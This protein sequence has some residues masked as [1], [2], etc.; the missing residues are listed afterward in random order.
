MRRCPHTMLARIEAY[1]SRRRALGYQL[2]S[3]GNYLLNFARYADEAGHRGPPRTSLMLRWA[4]LTRRAHRPSWAR[5]LQIVR[6]FAKDC[7][8]WEPRTQVPPRHFFGPVA[9]RPTPYLYSQKQM[10][11]LLARARRL[12]GPRQPQTYATLLGLLACTGLR[13]S[14]ALGLRVAD[15]DLTGGVLRINQSKY[16]KVRWVPLH[17]RTVARLR[18]YLRQRQR[19]FPQAQ[20]LFLAQNA[21][22]LTRT[23]VEKTFRGLRC[24]LADSGT[25]RLHDLRH[26]FAANVL[27]R[28]QAQKQGVAHRLGVLACYLGHNRVA[29][30]YWYLQAFPALLAQAG[31]GFR[32]AGK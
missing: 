16:H 3:E 21:S 18:A 30:T 26:T 31:R 11:M 4:R 24:G 12:P 8:G 32:L 6:C 27:L 1:L 25:P 17:A 7:Q 13:I 23:R 14:E 20:H 15:V 19:W 2:R 29:D 9:T 5:R 22:P 28:W 10:R